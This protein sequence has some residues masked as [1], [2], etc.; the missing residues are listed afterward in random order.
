MTRL[1]IAV[2]LSAAVVL[3]GCASSSPARKAKPALTEQTAK[4]VAA[5]G[6]LTDAD[7]P[8]YT[9]EVKKH[10]ASDDAGDKAFGACLGRPI[11][12]F[13]T[14]NFGRTFHKGT[15]EVDSA[16]D[17]ATSAKDGKAQLDAIGGSLGPGCYKK[18]LTGLIASSGA[19]V[20]SFEV[21]PVSPTVTHADGSFGYQIAVV[22]TGGGQT[23]TLKGFELGALVGQA[24]V[25]LTVIATGG[26]PLSLDESV[27]LLNTSIS[28][29][30]AATK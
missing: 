25:D 5:A 2:V 16:V 15:L 20:S 22:L 1:P 21:T 17:V 11:G 26:E 30:V 28:R 13:L 6:V 7:L 29:V 23:I 9:S 24:E 19:T 10:D 14:R 3:T 27:A 4:T 18:V 8:G 12:P